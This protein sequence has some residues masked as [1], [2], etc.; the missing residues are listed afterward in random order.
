MQRIAHTEGSVSVQFYSS[1]THEY[2]LRD[3]LGNTRVT[4]TDIDNNGL[5]DANDIAQINH[6]YP[7]G[8][9][10]EGNWQGGLNGQNKYQYNGKELNQDFGLD[11]NDYGARFYDPAIARWQTLDMLA[12]NYQQSSP[13]VYVL[14][15]PT[16]AIDPDGKRTY[17]VAGGTNDKGL[18]QTGYP[19]LMM[20]AFR[21][22]GISDVRQIDAHSQIPGLRMI[23]DIK[24][25]LGEFA[26]IPYW[27]IEYN[28]EKESKPTVL[29]FR[30]TEA[31][32][33]IEDDLQS[34]PLKNG[35]QFNLTGYSMGSVVV[36]QSALILADKGQR[37]DNLVLIG[38][39]IDPKSSLGQA[40]SE[41]QGNGKIGKVIYLNTTSDEV[42]GAASKG[43]SFAAILKIMQDV[44]LNPTSAHLKIA[45]DKNNQNSNAERNRMA[46][47][48]SKEGVH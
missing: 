41:Y 8:L 15:R 39:T 19:Q 6:Y 32:S 5:V 46:Q 44:F 48:L 45:G 34:N 37:I 31:V 42:L 36:A 47:E 13:Y 3:H 16:I 23:T 40:L 35:E 9:N 30:V 21:N 4:F 27:S 33:K 12:D 14:N 25:A 24:F 7:F 17:F 18:S 26:R 29:D 11:W 2:V 28:R 1:P 22:A 10:M 43:V 20:E 38:S